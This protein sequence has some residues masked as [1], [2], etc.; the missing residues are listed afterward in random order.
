MMKKFSFRKLLLPILFI[1]VIGIIYSLYLTFYCDVRYAP[2]VWE[3]SNAALSNPYQGF[4]TLYGY[5]LDDTASTNE[6]WQARLCQTA[7][8]DKHSLALLQINLNQYKNGEISQ[9]GLAQLDTI[10]SCWSGENHQLILR[11]LYDWDGQASQTEPENMDTVLLH[12]KQTAEL[13]NRYADHIYIIQGIFIGN[14]GEMHG[15]RFTGNEAVTT[16]F[17]QLEQA[18]APSIYL[19]VRTPAQWRTLTNSLA[20]ISLEE[21]Y[22]GTPASRLS[23]FNDGMLGSS[24]DLGSYGTKSREGSTVFS[25]KGTR[26]EELDFQF[27]LCRYVPNG[28]EVVIDNPLN[29]FS[30]A[31]NDLSR[32]HVSYLNDA[33]D[34]EVLEKW[35]THTY[36][37][38]DCFDSCTGYEYIERH[39]GYRYV[40]RSS[41]LSFQPLKDKE[42][43]LTVCIDN[44]GFANSY[45]AFPVTLLVKNE[46]SGKQL[47]ISGGDTRLWDSGE[48]T[49]LTFSIPV[50]ELD[51]GSWMLYLSVT[52]PVDNSLILFGNTA[53][54]V[55]SK[56]YYLGSLHKHTAPYNIY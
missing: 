20:P 37:G 49:S 23:L 40:L 22:Q 31:V 53:S 25:D 51:A 43:Q 39:L 5:R 15:S 50:R 38:S 17:H 27:E 33:Y 48:Q 7:A 35:K 32:M 52:N 18:A 45:I 10:L 54:P 41:S 2:V 6:E 13:V 16:L 14:Y 12:I 28:G 34:P 24:T 47:T 21:A 3:E 9:Q 30:N 36:T 11:F 29:N 26:S 56:G 55:A 8:A 19:A 46:V 4:Y 44:V 42:A 1:L